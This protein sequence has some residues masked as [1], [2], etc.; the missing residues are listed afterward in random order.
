MLPSDLHRVSKDHIFPICSLHQSLLPSLSTKTFYWGLG[1]HSAA[2]WFNL[3]LLVDIRRALNCVS[4][5]ITGQISELL[6]RRLDMDKNIHDRK[7][8][9][10]DVQLSSRNRLKGGQCLWICSEEML[11]STTCQT[12]IFIDGGL[13]DVWEICTLLWL[14]KPP[15]SFKARARWSLQYL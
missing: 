9:H 7:P 13:E 10:E 15:P 3:I 5:P 14:L 11:E 8:S 12:T 6:V 2:F 1:P 4:I